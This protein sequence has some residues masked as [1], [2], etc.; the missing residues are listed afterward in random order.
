MECIGVAK[1]MAVT[2]DVLNQPFKDSS[3]FS[4][5]D[6]AAL[7]FI[8]GLFETCGGESASAQGL[9]PGKRKSEQSVS[10]ENRIEFGVCL[11]RQIR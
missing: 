4:S 3:G 1:L 7:L 5:A 2:F 10:E 11:I 6:S 9:H 8:T